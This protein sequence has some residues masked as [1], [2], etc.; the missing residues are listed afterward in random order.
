MA[1][2]VTFASL[3][4]PSEVPEEKVPTDW[5]LCL[6]CQFKT[7]EP[8]TD[9]T[10]YYKKSY[11][12]NRTYQELARRIQTLSDLNALPS[13]VDV[14]RMDNGAGIETTLGINKAKWHTNCYATC[15]SKK[16]ERA[17]KKRKL[18]TCDQLSNM[19]PVQKKLRYSTSETASCSSESNTAPVLT[20]FFCDSVIFGDFHRVETL[21]SDAKIRKIAH[22]L[23]DSKLLMKLSCGDMAALDAVYYKN[24]LT[25]LYNQYRKFESAQNLP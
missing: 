24:C 22:D 20:C 5:K 10:N 23:T 18:Q 7:N 21:S 16:V 15:N 3:F 19:S 2:T 11:D 9:L 25:A 8:L 17:L 1:E 13:Y 14:N 12:T 6:F 4:G